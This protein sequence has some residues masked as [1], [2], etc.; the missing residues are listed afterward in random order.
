MIEAKCFQLFI[1]YMLNFL[2][3]L[4]HMDKV[5]LIGQ[6]M[7][8]LNS[9]PIWKYCLSPVRKKHSHVNFELGRKSNTNVEFSIFLF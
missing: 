8:D 1:R 4:M 5:R 6:E 3:C 9:I 2:R 7:I